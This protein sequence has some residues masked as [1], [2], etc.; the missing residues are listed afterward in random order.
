MPHNSVEG[1]GFAEQLIAGGKGAFEQG[2]GWGEPGVAVD[3]HVLEMKIPKTKI[4]T[5][6]RGD[7][8]ACAPARG[9]IELFKRGNGPH[10]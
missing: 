9:E 7:P 6:E 5:N 2:D 3:G 1:V 8:D 10:R 4:D